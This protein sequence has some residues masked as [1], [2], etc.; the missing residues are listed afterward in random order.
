M[1]LAQD[2]N[3]DTEAQG[4]K[5]G[6]EQRGWGNHRTEEGLA[7]VQ[8][9]PPAMPR[10]IVPMAEVGSHGSSLSRR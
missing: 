10:S 3:K 4:E 1:F 7:K 6:D 2:M 8:V 5:Q 9:P